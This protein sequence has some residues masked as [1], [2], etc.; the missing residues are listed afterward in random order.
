M[1]PVF[2]VGLFIFFI[3]AIHICIVS[4]EAPCRGLLV[5][6]RGTFNP[7]HLE[8]AVTELPQS[9]TCGLQSKFIEEGFV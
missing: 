9:G 3:I 8:L 7:L 2:Q 6:V 5:G 4:R 1:P